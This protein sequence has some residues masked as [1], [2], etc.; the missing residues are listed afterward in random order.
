MSQLRSFSPSSE[1][2]QNQEE[3]SKSLSK[4]YKLN[5]ISICELAPDKKFSAKMPSPINKAGT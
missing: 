5:R 3:E 2:S 1:E 4:G